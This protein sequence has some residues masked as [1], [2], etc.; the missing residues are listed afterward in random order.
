[1]NKKTV[2]KAI[3]EILD[4]ELHI[5]LVDL[6]LVYDVKIQKVAVEIVMT[7]TTPACPLSGVIK[8]QVENKVKSLPGIKKVSVDFSFDPLWT[9]DRI[10]PEIKLKLGLIK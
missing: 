4:P 1:M 9:P 10:A 6:G 2:L 3:G 7:L 8:K 5:S